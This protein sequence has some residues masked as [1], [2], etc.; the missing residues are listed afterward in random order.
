MIGGRSGCLSTLSSSGFCCILGHFDDDMNP[1]L[2]L[3]HCVS[4]CAVTLSVFIFIKCICTNIF[5]KYIHINIYM[6]LKRVC[7]HDDIQT[8]AVCSLRSKDEFLVWECKNTH[9]S[10]R[11]SESVFKG[12]VL[13][14]HKTR[15]IACSCNCSSLYYMLHSVNTCCVQWTHVA[16]SDTSHAHKSLNAGLRNTIMFL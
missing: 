13:P 11:S 1:D 12:A 7:C 9:R 3:K 15:V 4:C 16:F 5:C 2:T 8:D 10:G 14:K 6:R